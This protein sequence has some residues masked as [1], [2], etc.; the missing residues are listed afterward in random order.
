[1]EL[2][3]KKLVNKNYSKNGNILWLAK[4]K[5]STVV[6]GD[7]KGV[8]KVYSTSY[9][10]VCSVDGKIFFNSANNTFEA[11]SIYYTLDFTN[12]IKIPILNN[13]YTYLTNVVK[14]KGE[15]YFSF[16]GVGAS[17][18]IFKTKDFLTFT[19]VYS[20]STWTLICLVTTKD[21]MLASVNSPPI[22]GN[23]TSE[24]NSYL[25]ST[26]GATWTQKTLPIAGF[27]LKSFLVDGN[28]VTYVVS[29]FNSNMRCC[30]SLDGGVTFQSGS[31][32]SRGIPNTCANIGSK[33]VYTD[34]VGYKGNILFSLDGKGYSRK[35][36][37]GS[38]NVS[39]CATSEQFYFLAGDT[40]YTSKD[41]ENWVQ[42]FNIGSPDSSDI[43]VLI[44]V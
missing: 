1:M 12:F 18:Y 39:V 21:A 44:S 3:S 15:F 37:S 22:V 20:S 34:S 33:F 17:G 13:T 16:Q 2:W 11:N 4:N 31:C 35:N 29:G 26:D 6:L 9:T 42:S 25:Y 23:Y 43:S 7:S 14:F 41:G 36:I 24:Y 30:Y 19:Q 28:L 5:S 8:L 10:P 27:P 40:I 32:P 38:A